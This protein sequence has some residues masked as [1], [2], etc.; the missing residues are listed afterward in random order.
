MALGFIFERDAK[1][2]RD[3]GF[4]DRSVASVRNRFSRIKKGRSDVQNGMHKNSCR[5]CGELS[6]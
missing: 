4:K 6:N 3:A 5:V 2:V 1:G